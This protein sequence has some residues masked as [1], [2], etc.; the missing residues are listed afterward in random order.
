MKVP[1][2]FRPMGRRRKRGN[3][4]GCHHSQIMVATMARDASQ[5]MNCSSS[6]NCVVENCYF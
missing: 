5:L 1:L 6:F 2:S 3:W 4:F